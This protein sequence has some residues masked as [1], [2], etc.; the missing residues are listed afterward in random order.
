[1]RF[2]TS[3]VPRRAAGVVLSFGVLV[4]ALGCDPGTTVRQTITICTIDARSHQPLTDATVVW[5]RRDRYGPNRLVSIPE[6]LRTNEHRSVATDSS[7]CVVIT[8]QESLIGVG[9]PDIMT[10]KHFL[11]SVRSGGREELFDVRVYPDTELVGALFTI[12][13][14]EIGRPQPPEIPPP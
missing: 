7:G 6:Y 11:M 10:N 8:V 12:R 5:A 14:A 1:M 2:P 9:L 3:L 4:G 13:V